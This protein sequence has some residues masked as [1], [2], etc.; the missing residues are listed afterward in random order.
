MSETLLGAEDRWPWICS[1]GKLLSLQKTE[2]HLVNGGFAKDISRINV[3]SDSQGLLAAIIK[4]KR[5]ELK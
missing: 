1:A 3:K 4:I 2:L 5:Y